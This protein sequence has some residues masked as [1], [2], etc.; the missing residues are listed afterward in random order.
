MKLQTSILLRALVPFTLLM[1]STLLFHAYRD[2]ETPLSKSSAFATPLSYDELK[3]LGIGGN[4]PA[5]TVA[6]LVD[7]MKLWC[8]ELGTV[9][10][11]NVTLLQ[12]N[13]RLRECE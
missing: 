11:S 4:T 3:A 13:R 5:D 10:A 2:C 8:R 12:E 7:Q 6:M 9:R 1:G